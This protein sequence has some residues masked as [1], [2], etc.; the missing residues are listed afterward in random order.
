MSV[1]I[2]VNVFFI[3]NFPKTASI[4]PRSDLVIQGRTL[5]QAAY[6]LP[7][8]EPSYLPVLNTAIERPQLTAKSAVVYDMRSSRFL[9]SKNPEDRL[10]IASLTKLL[11]AVVVLEY[12]NP[13][14]IVIV[15]KESIKVDG[16][17]QTLYLDERIKVG[18]L[19]KMMLIE[20]SNDAAHALKLYAS[21][22]GV[23]LISFMNKKA[24]ELGM[25]DSIFHDPA[26]LNDDALSTSEDLVKLVKY[27]LQLDE[28]W[29]TLGE[30]T[31]SVSSIGGRI[32]RKINSTNQ[33]LGIIPDIVGGKTGYTEKALGCMIL[34][35][36]IPDKN[37]KLIIIVL[38]STERFTDTEKLT[39]W[40]KRAY[41]WE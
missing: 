19:L 27:S 23:D 14:D 34:V 25:N 5:N 8:S 9:Y 11:S 7:I 20:S 21:S 1:L 28:L 3:F 33:L 16:E 6:V 18:E 39:N 35:V 41:S 26:G 22:L 29:S 2:L 13:D 12:L 10:P 15:S 40:V 32:E 24:V 4:K 37:D 36:D 17:K 30:K 31:A 38:G